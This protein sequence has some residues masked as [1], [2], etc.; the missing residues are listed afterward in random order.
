[1]VVAQVPAAGEGHAGELQRAD[2]AV[3][4]P[5]V[6]VDALAEVEDQVGPADAG[7]PAEVAQADGEQLDL[8]PPAP[9]DVADLVDVAHH[10]GDVL[11]APL[12]AAGIVQ[13]RHSSSGY[14]RQE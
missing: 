5:G 13:D 8:V 11:R 10:R 9:E 6:P 12:V 2:D 1:M 14:L 7:E 4:V 3:L